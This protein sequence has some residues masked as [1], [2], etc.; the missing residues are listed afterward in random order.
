MLGQIAWRSADAP[1]CQV[2]SRRASR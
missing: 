1:D 2:P